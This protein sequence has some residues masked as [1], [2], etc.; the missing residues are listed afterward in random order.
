MLSVAEA[1]AQ[2]LAL[3]RPTGTETVPLDK[4]HGR[5]LA[6]PVVAGRA[7]PPFAASAMDGYAVR[8]AEMRPGTTFTVIGT[9][10]A[11][12][13]FAGTVGPGEAVRIFTGAPLPAGTDRILIQE[14]AIRTGA[15]ITVGPNPDPAPYV[16]PAGADF[17]V[18]A[19][20]APP[21]V[22]GPG[23]IAL[24][25]AM[26][27][28]ALCVARKPVVALIPTGDELV[29]PGGAP[30]PDQIVSSN[31]FGLAA[32][33]RD[34]GAETRLLPI[35]RDSRAAL[36]AVLALAEGADVIVTLGGASVGDHDLVQ[37]TAT[38]AGLDLSFYKIA[39][40]PGKPLMAGRLGAQVLIGLPGNPVSAMVCGR[41]FI[42]PLIAQMTGLCSDDPTRTAILSA[43]LPANG[44][45]QHF[46]RA[47]R[48]PDGTVRA[49]QRQ[50]SALLSVLQ[51]A[52]C[53]VVRPAYAP[54]LGIGAPVETLDLAWGRGPNPNISYEDV[55][56]LDTYQEQD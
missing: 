12:A 3:C 8:G 19:T 45:R 22:L 33:L 26:N 18:G 49:F 6:A 32:L 7:Q 50:D 54:A 40:R 39:M 31:N 21:R 29:M 2:V 15:R 28:P 53:L 27:C 11:G 20:L 52:D 1:R 36:S 17:R 41:L 43:P 37:S 47:R 5:V 25:A 55:D 56:R 13:A 30:R 34:A 4:A 14:D 16:R 42:C 44:P 23:D 46:M 10:P 24:A 51:A 38:E 35:A 48:G 9:A